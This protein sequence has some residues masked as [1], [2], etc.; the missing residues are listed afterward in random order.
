MANS[1]GRRLCYECKHDTAQLPHRMGEHERKDAWNNMILDVCCGAEKIYHNNQIKLNGNFI[2]MDERRGDFSYKTKSAVAEVKVVVDPMVL[3]DMQCLPFKDNIFDTVVCDPPHMDCGL[4]GFMGK[5][6]GSWGQQETIDIMKN[7]NI[8]FSRVLKPSGSL[9]LKVMKPIF[10]RFEK[11]LTNFIFYLP[12]QTVRARG[13]M[14]SNEAKQSALWF[15]AS[16]HA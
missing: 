12:I 8:E 16:N 1:H 3:A 9:I 7:A 13:C 15:I 2:T 5:A 4:T 10:P 11:M 6:W 14:E